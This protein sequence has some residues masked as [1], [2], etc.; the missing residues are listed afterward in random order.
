MDLGEIGW[1]ERDI[2]WIGPAQDRDKLK[3]F[4]NA[5]TNLRAAQNAGRFLDAC[6]T[7]SLSS[8]A[9]LQRVS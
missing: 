8:S 9:Q 3:T 5:I 7:G 2:V 4:V 1:R 6:T